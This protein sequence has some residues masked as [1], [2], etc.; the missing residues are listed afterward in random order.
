[1]MLVRGR[2][3]C[4]VE[5]TGGCQELDA[6]ERLLMREANSELTSRL[7]EAAARRQRLLQRADGGPAR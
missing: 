4:L 3:A 2:T 6:L 7:A 1:M 5:T